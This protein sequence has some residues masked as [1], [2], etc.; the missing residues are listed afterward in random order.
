[1]T[2]R[3]LLQK[4]GT[5]FTETG[6]EVVRWFADGLEHLFNLELLDLT[7]G[8]GLF[9]IV[10]AFVAIG[11]REFYRLIEDKGAMPLDGLG[12]AFGAATPGSH[13]ATCCRTHGFPRAC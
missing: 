2:I 4:I 6:S 9:T 3:E 7:I 1:M 11:Q 5:Y 12:V 10:M 8:Q 13:R